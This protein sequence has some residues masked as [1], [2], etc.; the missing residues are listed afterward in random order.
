[1]N[2]R[3]RRLHAAAVAGAC[4]W[5]GASAVGSTGE[6]P[7]TVVTSSGDT[8]A[9]AQAFLVC[10]A[11][12]SAEPGG[13][14]R[15]GPNLW[16]VVGRE[17]ASVAG[18]DY[19]APLRAIGGHWTPELLDRFLAD[20]S[21]LAPG[22]RMGLTGIADAG[23]RAQLIAY[24]DTLH[25]GAP[26]VAAAPARDFGPDWPPGPGSAEAGALCDSCHSLSL[27]KQQRLSRQTWD[28]L[29]LWMV[30]E[31]GMAEQMPETRELILGYLAEHFGAPDPAH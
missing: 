19:S 9:G 6:P 23:V 12:H 15:I 31:Q 24:L 7:A 10:N 27:V 8:A 21:G 17:V 26:S 18:F 28:R 1:M 5:L 3:T 4:S 25:D 11:C 13:A 14:A 29:L 16:N 2:G 20:P 30:E 22:T